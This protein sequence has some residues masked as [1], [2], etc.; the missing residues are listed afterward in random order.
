[1]GTSMS[2]PQRGSKNCCDG[3]S[4]AGSPAAGTVVTETAVPTSFRSPMA[5]TGCGLRA[6]GPGR[7][8]DLMR[9]EPRVSFEVDERK[10]PDR[11]RSVIEGNLR[12]DR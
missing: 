3:R 11:W 12:G 9:A 6:P 2:C 5:M 4:W 10:A 7:K 8:L 1:M